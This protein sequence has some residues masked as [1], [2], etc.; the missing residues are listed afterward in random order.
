MLEY[1]N[2]GAAH[3]EVKRAT[4]LDELLCAESIRARIGAGGKG[5]CKGS[6]AGDTSVVSGNSASTG[7]TAQGS[8]A[9]L[10]GS[11]KVYIYI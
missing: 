1:A 11:K 3:V 8:T 7:T 10:L 4:T 5:T 9:S 2:E 6:L